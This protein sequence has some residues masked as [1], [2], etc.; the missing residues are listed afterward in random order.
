MKK[1]LTLKCEQLF[2]STKGSFVNRM[3]FVPYPECKTAWPEVIPFLNEKKKKKTH[4]LTFILK[5]ADNNINF[6]LAKG[7][8][9]FSSLIL[10]SLLAKNAKA[11]F[12]NQVVDSL[13]TDK[14]LETA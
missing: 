1:P 6:S 11:Q 8:E 2:T 13:P 7:L 10:T 5:N 14:I 4:F 3:C 9:A 12:N